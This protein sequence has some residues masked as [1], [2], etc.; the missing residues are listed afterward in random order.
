MAMFSEQKDVFPPPNHFCL[1]FAN[2]LENRVM[3]NPNLI[4]SIVS[5]CSTHANLV[6]GQSGKA[7]AQNNLTIQGNQARGYK[8]FFMLN[9]IE[10]QISTAHKN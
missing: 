5:K 7:V 1:D 9:S 6:W 10:N 8:T 3:V 2:C 4:N